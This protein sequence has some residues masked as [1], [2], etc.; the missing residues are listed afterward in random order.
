M[1]FQ[2]ICDDITK[3]YSDDIVDGENFTR[4]GDG[5]FPL[6]PALI[7]D[8]L[9]YIDDVY[10]QP[11]YVNDGTIL[12]PQVGDGAPI[13][14]ASPLPT[15]AKPS[16]SI[17]ERSRTRPI[18]SKELD[19]LVLELDE[20]FSQMLLRK[21]DEK[22]MTDAQCYKKANI[23]RKLFSKIRSDVH[24]RPS[25]TTVLAFV[26]A[27]ELDLEEANDMLKKAGYA[28]SH[29][30]KFDIIIEYFIRNHRYNIYEINEVLFQF[31]QSLLG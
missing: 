29:S 16:Y 13:P 27:L 1:P 15:M 6:S 21:I 12:L 10:V 20:S 7:E 18:V 22:G 5:A 14:E 24:Y 30:S 17:P 11:Q 28:L 8:I 25:K 23:D 26:I 2:N 3:V 9:G 19:D 4:L 31:D